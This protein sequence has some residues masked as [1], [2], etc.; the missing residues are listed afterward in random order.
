M[1]RLY[2][3]KTSRVIFNGGESPFNTKGIK[4]NGYG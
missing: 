1:L 3:G 2:G 4:D